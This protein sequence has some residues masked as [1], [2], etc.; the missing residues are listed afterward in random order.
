MKMHKNSAFEKEKKNMSSLSVY[1]I[2]L[3]TS[4]N[5]Y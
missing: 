1:T 2:K 4:T 5:T 3:S